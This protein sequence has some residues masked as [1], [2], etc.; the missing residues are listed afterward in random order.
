MGK[1]T[2]STTQ[3]LASCTLFLIPKMIPLQVL[4]M[5]YQAVASHNFRTNLAAFMCVCVVD[6]AI[7]LSEDDAIT[8]SAED[9]AINHSQ[10]MMQ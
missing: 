6:D 1:C 2:H 7:T 8:L 9:D 4:K 10:S 3:V 5:W